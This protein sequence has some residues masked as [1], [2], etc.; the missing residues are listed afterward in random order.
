MGRAGPTNL[1]GWM[2]LRSLT[3]YALQFDWCT[4]PGMA[5]CHCKI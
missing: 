2:A 1:I 5:K 4:A 3:P